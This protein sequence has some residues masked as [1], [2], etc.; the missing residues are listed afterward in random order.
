M[1]SPGGA[2]AELVVVRSVTNIESAFTSM[3]ED[4][5]PGFQIGPE[6]DTGECL[7]VLAALMHR[8]DPAFAF[9][10]IS[11]RT[12]PDT[13]ALPHYDAGY[14]RTMA[15]IAVNE[16]EYGEGDVALR[17]LN[18]DVVADNESLSVADFVGPCLRGETRPGMKTVF[19]ERI[20][21]TD[22]GVILGATYHYF[23][24][25]G[26]VAR[27]WMRYTSA[28]HQAAASQTIY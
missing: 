25:K 16:V 23:G 9:D 7:L 13:I 26:D 4:P 12:N 6:V 2:T 28:G 5:L 17:L 19:S 3:V 15:G 14:A 20:Y 21:A 18:K 27:K 24:T 1:I 8:Y 22:R 11:G 10:D